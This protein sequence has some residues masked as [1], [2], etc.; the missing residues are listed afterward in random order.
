MRLGAVRIWS[1]TSAGASC[2]G[3]RA[4]GATRPRRAPRAARRWAR[5]A[6]VAG[7]PP[8][9]RLRRA[10]SRGAAALGAGLAGSGVGGVEVVLAA[11][12]PPL[13][14]CVAG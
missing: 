10:R 11:V 6:G 2:W 7:F 4:S 3:L 8:R 14:L 1:A 9:V 5:S 12:G 13:G